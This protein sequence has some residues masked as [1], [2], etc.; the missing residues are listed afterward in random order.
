MK[1]R[2]DLLI[3]DTKAYRYEQTLIGIPQ[4]GIDS[5]YLWNI[6]LLGK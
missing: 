1:K 6:Y 3:F 2:L 4:G 5:P